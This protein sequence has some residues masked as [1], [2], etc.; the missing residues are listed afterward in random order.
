MRRDDVVGLHEGTLGHLPVAREHL[1]HVGLL[2]PIL[3]RPAAEV[4]REGSEEAFQRRCLR[5]HVD[6]HEAAPAPDL[7]CR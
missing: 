5:I 3:E 2:V 1:G 6:E 7:D 4:L